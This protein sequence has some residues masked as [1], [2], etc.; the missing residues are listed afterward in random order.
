MS[1]DPFSRPIPM[2]SLTSETGQWGWNRPPQFAKVEDFVDSVEKKLSN[3]RAKEDILDMFIIGATVEDVV[4]TLA[5]SAVTQGK[6]TPDAA[7]LSKL[8]IAALLVDM[9]VKEDVPV[10]VFSETDNDRDNQ[11]T[12]DKLKLLYQTKPEL[13]EVAQKELSKRAAMQEAEEKEEGFMK[14]EKKDASTV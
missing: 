10:K 9:A 3:K 11:R 14:M 7:E 2:Q 13:F 8:P 5:I 6:I 12:H 1:S 4:N